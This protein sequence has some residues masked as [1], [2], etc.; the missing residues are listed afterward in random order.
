MLNYNQEKLK[1][2]N[3]VK[4]LVYSGLL[5]PYFISKRSGFG[6]KF[7]PTFSPDLVQAWTRFTSILVQF[8]LI[9][10]SILANILSCFCPDLAQIDS[11]IT[12]VLTYIYSWGNPSE[13]NLGQNCTETRHKKEPELN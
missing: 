8:Q 10:S 1:I 9:S 13:P 2:Y 7:A 5:C 11:S 6:P 3:I 4:I 12:Q